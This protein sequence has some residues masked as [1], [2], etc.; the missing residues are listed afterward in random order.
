MMTLGKK[1]TKILYRMG[2]ICH[3]SGRRQ[4]ARECYQCELELTQEI[5]ESDIAWSLCS[6]TVR[7]LEEL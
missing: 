4:S 1:Q 5:A 3:K 7:R 2:R 6:L